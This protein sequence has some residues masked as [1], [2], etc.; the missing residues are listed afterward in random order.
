MLK[1]K[2]K[3]LIPTYL[4]LAGIV[5]LVT[6]T[7]YKSKCYF[8]ITAEAFQAD[9]IQLYYDNDGK[10]HSEEHSIV[11]EAVPNQK[12]I[13]AFELKSGTYQNFRIRPFAASS[14]RK[15]VIS[16][17]D[18]TDE[19]G[20]EIIN[21]PLAEVSVW[22]DVFLSED[23]HHLNVE[24]VENPHDSNIIIL[25]QQE[26]PVNNTY[27]ISAI[28]KNIGWMSLGFLGLI[29][30]I[31]LLN[32]QN[33]R[34]GWKIEIA[35]DIIWFIQNNIQTIIITLFFIIIAYG[36]FITH[37]AISIDSELHTFR[38][39]FDAGFAQIGRGAGILLQWLLN[40]KVLPFW[41]DFFS[42]FSIFLSSLVWCVILSKHYKKS[43]AFLAFL[44]VYN[45]SPI[46]AF[47]LR[48]TMGNMG[49]YLGVL[50][51]SVLMYYLHKALENKR[52]NKKIYTGIFFLLVF[53][54]SL[55]E[56]FVI[57]YITASLFLIFMLTLE[58]IQSEGKNSYQYTARLILHTVCILVTALI[59]YYLI[60]QIV[61]HFLGKSEYT[62]NMFTWKKEN[63]RQILS[64][65]L[66]GIWLRIAHIDFTVL[67]AFI[68]SPILLTILVKNFKKYKILPI[69]LLFFFL[70]SP[71][72]LSI[73]LGSVLPLRTFQPLVFVAAI[74]WF[75][76]FDQIKFKLIQ[77]MFLFTVV[78]L[79]F[80]NAQ[81]INR[82]FY[83]DTMRLQYDIRLAN[84]IY[85]RIK[86]K[87]VLDLLKKPLLIA[88]N[89]S[90]PK[91]PFIIKSETIGASFFEWDGGSAER[92][93]RFMKWLGN[94]YIWASVHQ[95]P[96]AIEQIKTMPS[97]PNE[98]CIAVT[99][100]YILLK[101]SDYLSPYN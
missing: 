41:N 27:K 85:D 18:I 86:S 65:L 54:I 15:L 28:G 14:G 55:Y 70:L 20:K 8:N 79:T 58:N 4:F 73:I 68:F 98:D 3:F 74:I 25:G 9:R 30:F 75:L 19:N 44:L 42:I 49:V 56:I 51:L 60:N 94:E 16:K 31:V 90:H 96:L 2:L 63:Y 46:Y 80:F 37:W 82:L 7:T 83:G 5:A 91:Q 34:K 33:I 24:A 22:A 67:I 72:L 93:H 62:S 53:L 64:G 101:L 87:V 10:G 11:L 32:S 38:S 13:Y 71:F 23:S 17:I 92:M 99:D 88:G 69:F 66:T 57:Y 52:D 50:L 48:F 76:W 84:Q 39:N 97:W 77:Q 78:V 61:Y 45:I 21:Y 89:Y 81:Y 6:F 47:F 1:K 40:Y 59:V 95:Y 100:E 35:D 12:N 43:W 29:F 36:Y 26:L